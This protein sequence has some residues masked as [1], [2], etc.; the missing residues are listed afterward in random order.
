MIA[1]VVYILLVHKNN[2]SKK[3]TAG[4]D[5]PHFGGIGDLLDK[6]DRED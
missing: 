5:T 1:I 4:E 2:R 6:I 3:I